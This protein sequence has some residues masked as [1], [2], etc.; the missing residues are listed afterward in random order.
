MLLAC[1]FMRAVNANR[2][3]ISDSVSR[4]IGILGAVPQA[5]DFK[6]IGNEFFRHALERIL[7]DLPMTTPS[8]PHFNKA[9][10]AKLGGCQ[11]IA[12][13]GAKRGC[14]DR[15]SSQYWAQ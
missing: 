7:A 12:A 4:A 1:R 10:E 11:I 9:R 5:L 8:H 15:S 6:L 13:R 3:S 2:P 14:A